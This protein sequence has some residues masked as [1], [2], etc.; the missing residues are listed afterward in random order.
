[1]RFKFSVPDAVARVY[2]KF[3]S[4]G[5][6]RRLLRLSG[7]DRES[8]DVFALGSKYWKGSLQDFSVDPNANIGQLRSNNNFMSEIAKAHSKLYSLWLIYKE[9]IQS[10]HLREE[11]AEKI[12]DDVITGRLYC[13]DQTLWT[14][15]YCVAVSTSVLMT[16]GRPYGQL[17]SKRPKRADSF[18]SQVIEYTMDLSQEFAGAVALADLAVNYSWYVKKENIGDKQIVNDFQ[19]FVHVVNNQYRVGGQSPFTNISFYDRKTLESI[20]SQYY[21]PDGS[22]VMDYID[23]IERV[24]E[25]W[26][27]FIAAKD[28]HSGLPY[29]FPVCTVNLYKSAEGIIPDEKFLQL[30]CECNTEG[31]FNIFITSDCAQ[32]ASCCRLTSSVKDLMEFRGIDS[33]GNGG[34]NIGSHRVVTVNLPRVGLDCGGDPGKVEAVI[35]ERVREACSILYSHRCLI[36]KLI[37]AGYLKFFSPLGWLNLDQMF[38]ST[39]GLVGVW[40]LGEICGY[41]FRKD[42][43]AL[44]RWLTCILDTIRE[45]SLRWN[46]PFN[47]EQVPAESAAVTLCEK[48]RVFY[49]NL[50]YKLYSNQFIPLWE[51]VELVE[52]IKIGGELDQ[53]FS[54]GVIT[55]L[56]I[57]SQASPG[58]VRKLI[59]Y[60]TKKGLKHFAINPL[61]SRCEQGHTF[62]GS[63]TRCP[64]CSSLITEQV[65]RVIGYFVPVSSMIRTRQEEVRKSRIFYNLGGSD[66]N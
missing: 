16:Q 38:F 20:F 2:N 22:G 66:G 48:D 52:R 8:I 11:Q 45:E 51:P 3:H 10:C 18:I 57:G 64:I 13:H 4:T 36:E 47:L 5:K 49:S 7:I 61:F 12:L 53:Y 29:R 63:A 42:I 26:M 21:Y 15:P 28:P 25:L 24:Q 59:Q 6:G 58:Q 34:L 40:E 41:D 44:K 19:R 55:H 14:V 37:R 23:V 39:V 62:L 27:R 65:T 31:V 56:N 35:K 9:L 50:P 46:V 43:S 1:M 54:G 30:V 32:I 17:Y 60:A 33:F